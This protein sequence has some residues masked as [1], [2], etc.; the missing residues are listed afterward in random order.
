MHKNIKKTRTVFSKPTPKP[1]TTPPCDYFNWCDKK[2]V[3]EAAIISKEKTVKNI[4]ERINKKNYKKYIEDAQKA[5]DKAKKEYKNNKDLMFAELELITENEEKLHSRTH[6]F[7]GN[8]TEP[9][10]RLCKDLLRAK[11]DQAEKRYQKLLPNDQI[12]FKAKKD[13]E[14]NLDNAKNAYNKDSIDAFDALT[15]IDILKAEVKSIEDSCDRFKKKPDC[16]K[17]PKKLFEKNK[18]NARKK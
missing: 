12:L 9:E 7:F 6:C 1:S 18:K 5:F 8:T 15:L 16:S 10:R 2:P 13:A 17:P 11:I 14:E 3:L 4:E